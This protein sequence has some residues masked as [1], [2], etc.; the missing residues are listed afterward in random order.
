MVSGVFV[1]VGVTYSVSRD[2]CQCRFG[3]TLVLR[4][5]GLYNIHTQKEDWPAVIGLLYEL[6]HVNCVLR[7]RDEGSRS[8]REDFSLVPGCQVKVRVRMNHDVLSTVNRP[9]HQL[10]GGREIT[11][12]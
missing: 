6:G 5:L 1:S 12:N 10:H 3:Y 4:S 9:Y 8:A 11:R 7:F 2:S